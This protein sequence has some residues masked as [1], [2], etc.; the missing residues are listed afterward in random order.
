MPPAGAKDF[1]TLSLVSPIICFL[2]WRLADR[3]F[4]TCTS[5]ASALGILVILAPEFDLDSSWGYEARDSRE[6]DLDLT[7]NSTA[8]GISYW[9]TDTVIFTDSFFL[10]ELLF[11]DLV[12]RVLR[13]F[14]VGTITVGGVLLFDR[15]CFPDYMIGSLEESSD[16]LTT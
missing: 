6:I 10:L 7:F 11:L 8:S 5:L 14:F 2:V 13:E 16:G 1:S 4:W 12:G 9:A 15:L 3:F